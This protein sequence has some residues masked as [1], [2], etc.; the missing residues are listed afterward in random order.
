MNQGELFDLSDAARIL[1]R[2]G[3][4]RKTPAK[5]IAARENG[6]LGGRPINNPTVNPDGV[7]I[8][9]CTIIYAPRGQAGEYSRL[10]TNPYR[11]CGHK[12]RYCYVPNVLRMKRAEF[13]AGAVPRHNFLSR[14]RRDAVKY[15]MAGITNVNIML[16][17]TT[18]PYHPG[19][20]SLTRQTIQTLI[21]Q[22]LSF[23]VLTKGGTRS[24]RDLDLFRKD[25]DFFACTVTSTE[26]TFA[27][28]W[29]P[30]A[31]PPHDRIAALRE[32]AKHGIF[33]WV[34]IE[35]TLSIRHAL[36]VVLST[37]EFVDL[38][39]IGKA[40]YIGN[41]DINWQRYT[42][43]IVET[44]QRFGKAYYIKKDLQQYLPPDYHNPHVNNIIHHH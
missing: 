23:G 37:H 41:L 3:G 25:R 4:K 11:G 19:D 42:L 24:F 29:E 6:S 20:T 9:G 1:G 22:D 43:E 10:A 15:K 8:K 35:P 16:S 39:K 34:S 33:T 32:F 38:Y 40:N 17:F 7:S 18:D 2:I 5:A 27:A 36:D 44:L 12:C 14:L 21:E 13:D 26:P 31:A 28:K 30:N